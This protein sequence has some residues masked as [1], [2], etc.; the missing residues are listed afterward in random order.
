MSQISKPT[1]LPRSK[2]HQTI[3]L[4]EPRIAP[5][6]LIGLT[7]KDALITF[8]SAAPEKILTSAKVT[9]LATGENLVSLDSRPANG[10][11]YGLTNKGSLYTVN[12]YSG[13]ATLVA[14]APADYP[15]TGKVY[16]IDFN[17]TVD[18]IRVVT[19]AELNYRINPTTGAYVDGDGGTPGLQPDTALAYNTGDP[20]VGK[21]P[22]ITAVAYDRNFQ[23]ATQTTL[24]AIDTTRNTLVMIGA[25]NGTPLSPNGG[26]LS[27]VGSLGINPTARAGFDIS[28]D[29]TAYGAFKV[30]SATKLYTINL[31]L[32]AATAIGKIGNGRIVLDAVT[33][34]PLEEVVV[35]VTAS[36]RLIS[37]RADSPG[38]LLSS[39]SLT[40]L[41]GGENVSSIDF[42]PL[43]GEL[44]ALTNLNR[45]V[46]IDRWTGATIVRGATID[47]AGFAA[48]QFTGIDFNPTVDR[49]RLVNTGNDNLRYN[50]VTFIPVDTNVGTAALDGDTDLAYIATDA[51]VG[52]DPNI[53][54]TAYDRNDNDG[55]TATTLF[56]IDSNLDIL[57][58]QGAVDGNAADVAGGGSPNNGLLTTLGSLGVDPTNNVS[59]DISEVGKGGI[60]A[61]LAAMQLTGEATS[62][63]FSINLNAGLTNQA[64][65]TA[66]LIGEIGGGEIV[67]AMAIASG[68]A[69]FSVGTTIVKEKAGTFAT[70]EITRTG[71]SDRSTDILL[72]T[73]DGSAISGLDYT[74]IVNQTV[75]FA[76]GETI[77]RIQIPILG[78]TLAETHE[79]F[80]LQLSAPSGGGTLTVG[81][82]NMASIIIRGRNL[83]L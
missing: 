9:G 42:R 46:T 40:G 5:S 51:N 39:V 27:T 38:Q 52:Q 34:A 25:L 58:R 70:I 76:R 24:Y 71:G 55:A 67:T 18:R 35:G 30:G 77:K 7:S 65:G 83:A 20:N 45:I 33:E 50:P 17:P 57:V 2:R 48:G 16:A 47:P 80:S 11:V 13:A 12:P 73:L 23:G 54:A 62:K 10:L 31:A 41:L 8:D 64:L 82:Q 56:A 72:N 29:G 4:L 69:Q 43:T 32:G 19:E 74:G 22:A 63:L 26:I 44:F 66:T 6:T 1:Q 14:N 68:T 15:F 78:D 53:T 36:N 3:E 49:L 61:A 59:F 75:S 81:W 21:N 37:F 79:F 28:A 60:G